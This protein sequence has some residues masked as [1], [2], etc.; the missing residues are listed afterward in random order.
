MARPVVAYG[1]HGLYGV[2]GATRA[3]PLTGLYGP[4]RPS[5]SRRPDSA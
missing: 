2:H 3:V 1:V 5:A 4:E